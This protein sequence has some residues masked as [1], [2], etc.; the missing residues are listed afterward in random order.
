[1]KY[2]SLRWSAVDMIFHSLVFCSYHDFLDSVAAYKSATEPTEGSLGKSWRHYF[3]RITVGIKTWLTVTENLCNKWPQICSICRTCHPILFSFMI[4]HLVCNK[5]NMADATCRLGTTHPS[6]VLEFTSDVRVVRV[7]SS[8][9]FCTVF[10]RSCLL[11]FIWPLYYQ[12]YH[13]LSIN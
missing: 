2:T 10:C 4:Y 5:T 9:V 3:D 12:I 6:R 1:M 7:A 11:C 8:L 13:K